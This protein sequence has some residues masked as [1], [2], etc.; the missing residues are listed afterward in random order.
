MTKYAGF[1]TFT[2]FTGETITSGWAKHW[3]TD[4]GTDGPISLDGMPSGATSPKHTLVTSSTN[5][6]RWAFSLT[7]ATGKSWHVT[8]KDCAFWSEDNNGTVELS[9]VV[10]GGAADFHIKPPESGA[11]DTGASSGVATGVAM[12]LA[13][14]HAPG[15]CGCANKDLQA[16]AD[17]LRHVDLAQLGDTPK[18]YCK[19]LPGLIQILS[20]IQT[21][22][23]AYV[24]GGPKIGVDI[25]F[26]ALK[27]AMQAPCSSDDAAHGLADASER[28]LKTR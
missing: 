9:V 18:D 25:A 16:L 15:G 19:V 2:N 23:D 12:G 14:A 11:C 24:S 27:A 8:E 17:Q 20:G 5:K 6:D 3:T 7:T 4:Y 13:G 1:Y 28:S 26:S 21:I 22:T 10:A